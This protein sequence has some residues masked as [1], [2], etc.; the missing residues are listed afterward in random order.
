MHF[1]VG[2]SVMFTHPSKVPPRMRSWAW[3]VP[4]HPPEAAPILSGQQRG[5]QVALTA[6]GSHRRAVI[7]LAIAWF[8]SSMMSALISRIVGFAV[9]K[10]VP[11]ADITLLVSSVTAI[12][13]TMTIMFFVDATGDSLT[14]LS[15]SRVAHDLR[16]ELVQ[17][18]VRGHSTKTPGEILNTVDEDAQQVGD[19]KQILNFPLVMVGYLA[20]TIIIVA[21]F[22]WQ[23][24]SLMFLGGVG[25]AVASYFT[26]KAIAKISRSRRAAEAASIS[27]ATDYAQGS[28]VLKGLGAVERAEE[29]FTQKATDALSLMLDDARIFALTN[30][31]RQ[32]IPLLANIAVLGCAGWFAVRGSITPGEF[33][34]VTLVAPPALTVM[35]FALGF[36]TDY[37][38]RAVA[39][40][41]R[42]LELAET[43]AITAQHG[44]LI[45]PTRTGLEVWLTDTPAA[46]DAARSELATMAAIQVPH[47]A[48]IFEGTLADNI[49]P[50]G[51]ATKVKEAL[52][53][54]ACEDIIRRLGGFSPN[55]ELP[56]AAIG[57]AGLNL[58]G[59]QRQ[60]V[61]LARVL[62]LDPDVLVLDDPTTG[63]DAVTLDNVA[64]ATKQLREGKLT[65]VLTTSRG[66]VS[67]ADRIVKKGE[68]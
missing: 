49:D 57:E 60:R 40:S 52:E 18:L 44:D 50:T 9:D 3:F 58:S 8:S 59:G 14:T 20:S 11:F 13:L 46:R 29:K 23:L 7:A 39:S 45:T 54:A 30:F 5:F 21:Q 33:F 48:N 19:V 31:L 2:L 64:C 36:L 56:E 35:G 17:R 28:R 34:T 55:G 27:L 6:L 67:V 62:A 15:I 41:G 66:W 61:A 32:L 25:T 42:V 37:W 16:L 43:T 24:A 51:S 63:L 53:A 10:V 22:S 47:S 38:A 26:G 4:E 68:R 1:V 12:V 65:I